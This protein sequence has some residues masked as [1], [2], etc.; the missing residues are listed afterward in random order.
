[1]AQT[2]AI[3]KALKQ[4]LKEQGKS[5]KDVAEALQL[6]EASIKRLFSDGHFSL[7]RIDCICD[8]L[9]M[10]IT[11]LLAEVKKQQ[12]QLKTLTTEQ[13]QQ[14]VADEALFIIANSVLNRWSFEK[15]LATYQFT[16]PEL[17]QYLARLDS[18]KLIEL[19]PNNRIKLI[20]DRSFSWIKGGPIQ[21][22]FE[23]QVQNEFL[24]SRFNKP[25][26]K[27]LFVSG[28]LSRHANNL[29]QQKMQRLIDDFNDQA[30][31][32]ENLTT[33]ERFGTSLIVAMRHWEPSFFDKRRRKPDER[34]F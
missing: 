31:L 12:Q 5:Y 19:Q 26:E 22:Y 29:L 3:V 23:K 11:D 30:L 28:M 1:M 6:S 24:R 32:D 21:Q 7:K 34:R 18:L 2:T 25:G 27:R 4:A 8:M 10:E 14:L 16:T 33:D 17:I 13:E 15:I 9:G 20:V